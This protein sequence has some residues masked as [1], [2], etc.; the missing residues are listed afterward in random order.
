MAKTRAQK[1]DHDVHNNSIRL[2][3]KSIDGIEF[4]MILCHEGD[5]WMGSEDL[6]EHNHESPRH[7]VKM[8]KEFWIGETQ[9]TQELWEHLMGWNHSY[10][11]LSVQQPVDSVTWYDCLMFCNQLSKLDGFEP[12]FSLTDVEIDKDHMIKAKVEWHRNANGYRLPT[13]AEW[14]YSAKA[15]TELI[16]SGSNDADEV[17]WYF[18]NSQDNGNYTTHN[19]KTKK[20]NKWGLYDMSGNI[21]EWCM[22][23]WDRDAYQK[24]ND[25]IENPI[26]WT[27][28]HCERSV[29]GGSYWR[30]SN[31]CRVAYRNRDD[32]GTWYHNQGLRLLRSVP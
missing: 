5:F 16:Y 8:S 10:S 21:W 7:K 1:S 32:A 23:Q 14:E 24:R 30:S 9:V 18:D 22:D 29:R 2:D 20:P 19:V 3:Q 12:C 15:S 4:N 31:R 28:D 13:E 27:Q 25:L 17:A 26:L 6:I 11:K